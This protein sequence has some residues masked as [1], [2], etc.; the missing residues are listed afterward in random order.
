[1]PDR[2]PATTE[3]TARGARLVLIRDARLFMRRPEL[4]DELAAGSEARELVQNELLRPP[5][6]ADYVLRLG[7]LRVTEFLPDGREV[8]RAVLQAGSCFKTREAAEHG[9]SVYP[10]ER[11]ALMALDDAEVWRLPAGTFA[12]LNIG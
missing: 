1:M 12:G 3:P 10:L 2:P 8:T 6:P 11:T 4:G 7:R 9:D 5:C